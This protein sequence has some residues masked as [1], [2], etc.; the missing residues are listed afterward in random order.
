MT[1]NL[2][3]KRFISA[4]NQHGL[5]NQDTLFYYYQTDDL[6]HGEY[7]GGAIREGRFLGKVLD[8]AHKSGRRAIIWAFD[9]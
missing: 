2:N 5:A 6:I 8:S 3:G 7:R 1:L 4:S 9:W